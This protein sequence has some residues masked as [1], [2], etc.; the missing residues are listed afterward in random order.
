MREGSHLD[1]N[2]TTGYN[3]P[4]SIIKLEESIVL[5]DA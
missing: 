1:G 5:F 3:R 4:N 2:Q